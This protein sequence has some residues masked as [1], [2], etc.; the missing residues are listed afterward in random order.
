MKF[1][2]LDLYINDKKIE[3]KKTFLKLCVQNKIF[4]KK[5]IE[6][7][8]LKGKIISLI[9][10]FIKIIFKAPQNKNWKNFSNQI[11]EEIFSE[12]I[13]REFK[14]SQIT[15]IYVTGDFGK[16]QISP[17]KISEAEFLLHFFMQ[18]ITGYF[19]EY[20]LKKKDVVLDLGSYQ[21][22]FSLASS[23]IVGKK[24]KI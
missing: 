22:Y 19:K 21:G 11:T 13:K 10:A 23:I 3:D 7:A 16:I 6:I 18:E 14:L 2:N 20:S 17:Q 5:K 1:D 12:R 8:I 24:G 9:K 15:K 4:F